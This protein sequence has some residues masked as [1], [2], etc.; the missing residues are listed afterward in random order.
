MPKSSI[1]VKNRIT[2]SIP[3]KEQGFI[4][5]TGRIVS[6]VGRAGKKVVTV[7]VG[8]MQG[9][10][11]VSKAGLSIGTK[12]YLEPII[13]YLLGT[14]IVGSRQRQYT[15]V[16]SKKVATTVGERPDPY[17]P[18]NAA[19]PKFSSVSPAALD[20]IDRFAKYANEAY[21]S[22]TSNETELK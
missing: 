3:K 2:P 5:N 11:N 22:I 10:A 20:I 12:R 9:L 1:V 15:G 19:D 21:A 7:P 18:I 14:D 16:D 8:I 13:D 4:K 6:D 17:Y